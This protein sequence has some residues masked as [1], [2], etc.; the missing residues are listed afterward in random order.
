M[1]F[2]TIDDDLRFFYNIFPTSTSGSPLDP[3][4]RTVLL[5]HPRFFDH[6]FFVPQYTDQSWTGR[7]NLIALDHHYH[8]QTE[9]TMD[10]E[11]YDFEKVSRDIFCFLDKLG[12]V[13]CHIFGVSLGALIATRMAMLQPDRVSSLALCPTPPP[14][15]NPEH[16]A[17]YR[18]I[19]SEAIKGDEDVPNALPSDMVAAARML[20]FGGKKRPEEVRER[21]AANNKFVPSNPRLLRKVYS[22]TLERRAPPVESWKRIKVPVLI[23]HGANDILYPTNVAKEMYNKLSE[24]QRKEMHLIEHGAHLFTWLQAPSINPIYIQFIE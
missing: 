7:F 9:V 11:P 8:G 3:E 2:L 6:E 21:W 1:P 19:L 24:A 4:K 16:I 10:D 14:A 13:T 20:L 5:L 18:R 22:A 12:V 17:E 15:D 23:A